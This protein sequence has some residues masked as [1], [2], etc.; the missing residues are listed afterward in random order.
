MITGF[1]Y[2]VNQLGV[3]LGRVLGYW[4]HHK[5]AYALAYNAL[6]C[7]N[8]NKNFKKEKREKEN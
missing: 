8:K 1:W 6:T 4:C 2:K 3:V 5:Y 7:K